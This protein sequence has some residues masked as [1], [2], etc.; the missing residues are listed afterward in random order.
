MSTYEKQLMA[1]IIT[2]SDCRVVRVEMTEFEGYINP[3]F[4]RTKLFTHHLLRRK[5]KKIKRIFM[6]S[7]KRSTLTCI[8]KTR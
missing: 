1:G 2:L 6:C 4:P 5:L 7:F 3:P 8:R